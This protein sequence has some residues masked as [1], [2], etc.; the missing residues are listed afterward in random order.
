MKT[1][2]IRFANT[3]FAG[4]AIIL[5]TLLYSCKAGA[6]NENVLSAD[7]AS[8]ILSLKSGNDVVLEN[9]TIRGDLDLT[10]SGEAVLQHEGLKFV[11]IIGSLSFRNCEFLGRVITSKTNDSGQ[12]TACDFQKN[13]SFVNCIF[14]N[15]VQLR[16]SAID[17]ICNFQGSSFLKGISMEE[18]NV[19][20]TTYFTKAVFRGETNMQNCV[21]SQKADFFETSFEENVSFQGTNFLLET[22]FNVAKFYKYADFSVCTFHHNSFFNYIV[23]TGKM[24]FNTCSFKGRLDCIGSEFVSLD[25]TNCFLL[26]VPKFNKT[27]I[28]DTINFSGAQFVSGCPD[29]TESGFKKEQILASKVSVASKLLTSEDFLKY[30]FQGQ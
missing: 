8:I 22:S 23:S 18:L 9:K 25:M 4:I 19:G 20:K 3:G 28:K 6:G 17:G 12:V 15:E 26:T 1:K 13:F 2:K 30:T 29:L 11:F 21:F 10:Q 5:V 16:A 7:P 24:V 14:Q 27:T